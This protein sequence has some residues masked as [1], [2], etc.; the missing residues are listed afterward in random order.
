MACWLLCT[1]SIPVR[2]FEE[3]LGLAMKHTKIEKVIG[4]QD[5]LACV[6]FKAF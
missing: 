6:I 4:V 1:V 3:V 5:P 2:D